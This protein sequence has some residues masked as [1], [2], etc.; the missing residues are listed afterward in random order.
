MGRPI[1]KGTRNPLVFG[2]SRSSTAC[3]TPPISVTFPVR[4]VMNCNFSSLCAVAVH[5]DVYQRLVFGSPTAK[6]HSFYGWFCSV[7]FCKAVHHSKVLL[8]DMFH[9]YSL[10]MVNLGASPF[11]TYT[12]GQYVPVILRVACMTRSSSDCFTEFLFQNLLYMEYFVHVTA[13]FEV[14]SR[15]QLGLN[16][17]RLYVGVHFN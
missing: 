6:E 2:A 13:V 3:R 12:T 11:Q 14:S 15:R 16:F 4:F 9:W 5:C 10:T 17:P 1:L 8:Y 7:I